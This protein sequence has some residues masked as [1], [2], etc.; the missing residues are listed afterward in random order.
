MGAHETMETIAE[1]SIM[2][3]AWRG[4]MIGGTIYHFI[5]QFPQ[6]KDVS[7]CLCLI[8]LNNCFL[9][10]K[11][12]SSET[13]SAWLVILGLCLFNSIFVSLLSNRL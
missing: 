1:Y 6:Q 2:Q 11:I 7:S 5:C 3:V 8:A 13:R 12:L 10:L 9:A 4:G